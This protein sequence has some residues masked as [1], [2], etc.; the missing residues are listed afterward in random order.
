MIRKELPAPK[1]D[2]VFQALFRKGNEK[3]TKALISGIIGRKIQKIDLDKNKN[4]L[5]EYT[6]DKMGI[7]DL[8][9]TLDDGVICNIEVQL[10]DNKDIEKRL[11]YYNAKIYSQ[12]MLIGEKYEDLKK[13]ISI[14][15]LDYNLE[16]L[17]QIKDAH[18]IWHLR[19]N[20][21]HEEI[22]T[23]ELE[24]HIIEIPKI[25]K[26]KENGIKDEI[27]DWMTFINN[28]NEKEV[29]DIVKSNK[30]IEEAMKKLEEIGSDEELMRIINLRRKA[31]L[32]ENQRKY[33]VEKEKKEAIEKALEQG[34]KE[35]IKEGRKEIMIIVKEM[36]KRNMSIKEI[37]EITKLSK[38]EIKNIE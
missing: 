28:P 20:K 36:L 33:I 15:I 12:Q 34:K 38:D 24:V 22:L 19:E 2:V 10:A 6:K 17:N 9:A 37:M 3:I 31:I 27:I 23:D 13:T 11:L 32:D 21:S 7:L 8:I 30:E 26:M 4:L 5:R 1:M 18:T 16:Q 14:A 25:K 29:S 35:G